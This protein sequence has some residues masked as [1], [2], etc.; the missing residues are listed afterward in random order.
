MEVYLLYDQVTVDS[1]EDLMLLGLQHEDHVPWFSLCI[2]SAS[3][4]PEEDLGAMLVTFL[5]VHFKDLLLRLQALHH[6]RAQP[7]V[8]LKLAGQS[9]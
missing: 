7:Y 1:P 9:F 4:A 5:N 2:L 3:L 6:T 8:G